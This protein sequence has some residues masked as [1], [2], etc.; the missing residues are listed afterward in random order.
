MEEIVVE[1]PDYIRAL[2]PF[3]DVKLVKILSGVRRCGKSTVL[4]LWKAELIRRGVSDRN[5]VSR[6]YSEIT[7]NITVAD[8]LEDLR[9]EISAAGGHCYVFLDEVQEVDGWEKCVNILLEGEDVDIYVTG[10][11]SKLT[12]G[13]LSTYLTGRFVNIPVYTLSFAEYLAFK[14]MPR[15][16][17]KNAFMSYIVYGGFPLIGANDFD[18]R[19]AYQVVEG[20]YST[21]VTRDITVRHRITERDLFDR[22]VD[23]IVENVGKTFSANSVANFLKS[24]RRKINIENI[25]NYIKWLEEAFIIYPCKR[26]ELQGKSVLKTQEK[27]YLSDVSLKYCRRGYNPAMISAALENI[28]YLEMR[29]RGYDVYIGKLGD[30]EIDFVGKRFGDTIYIQV[31]RN[32]PESSSRETENLKAI[33]DHYKKYVVTLD[34]YAFGNDSGIEFVH[35]ADFLLRDNW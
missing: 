34:E 21:V 26:L 4:E 9:A 12:S 1:R 6:K 32:L 8:M 16:E 15:S 30:K 29:R 22:V 33:K 3:K 14:K 25:Y 24:E 28:V 23:F 27:Y 10:S 7:D 5:I 13:E 35:A 11:N 17:A 20:I 19:T 2:E 31:C 18:E